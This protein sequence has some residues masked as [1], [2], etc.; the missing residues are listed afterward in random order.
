MRVLLLI[1]LIALTGCVS[2]GRG[3]V[4]TDRIQVNKDT[5]VFVKATDKGNGSVRLRTGASNGSINLS[6]ILK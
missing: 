6:T 4:Y 2:K 3:V 5:S 1:G